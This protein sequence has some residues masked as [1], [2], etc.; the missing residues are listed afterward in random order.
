M[1]VIDNTFSVEKA[2]DSSGFLLWQVTNL[3]QREI[4]KALEVYGLTHS[5]FVLMASIHWLML[6]NQEVTQ[7]I[8]SNHT[9]ID[10]MTTSTVLRTLQQKGLIQ[11]QEHLTDTRAKT[12]ELTEDG[13]EIIKKA[14]VTVEQFDKQFFSLLGDKTSVLNSHLLTLLRQI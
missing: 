6:H 5:Q 2:E 12:V 9:K 7:V 13:K 8:L 14:V 10:P 4:K 3:W 1:K 11:R